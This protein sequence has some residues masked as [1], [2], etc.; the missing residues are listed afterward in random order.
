MSGLR[1]LALGLGL[2]LVQ[3]A[4]AQAAP[5]L[6]AL[7]ATDPQGN[8]TQLYFQRAGEKTLAEPVASLQHRTGAAVQGALLP[9]TRTVLV[10]ADLP[11]G[12]DLS[13][14]AALFRLEPGREAVLLAD[15]VYHST[16]PLVA[17]GRVF[18]QRGRAGPEPSASQAEEGQLRVDQLTIEEIDLATGRARVVHRHQGYLA[19]LAAALEEELILY[20][21]AYRHADLVAVNTR[22][23]A[24]R[25]LLASLPS[26]A[27][28]FSL[29]PQARALLYTQHDARTGR[30]VVERLQLDT[31][32]REQL[33]SGPSLALAPHWWPGGKLAFNPGLQEG[34]AVGKLRA[35]LGRGVDHLRAFS[36]DGAFAVGLHSV[37]GQFP[38]PFALH[39]ASGK[40][41][42]LA[43]PQ[44]RRIEVAGILEGADR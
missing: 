37:G 11:A 9:G 14:G 13:F 29:D 42:P 28:D 4:L 23:G 34:L 32:V 26:F 8:S 31:L 6:V 27:R 20:R 43:F 7:L 10:V 40:P 36:L 19:F 39:T 35:P 5:P 25:V 3:T 2:G 17:Q 44:G 18:V 12:S 38:L 24:A 16:R 33:A 21:V 1:I 30:W 22:S 15:R 41:L